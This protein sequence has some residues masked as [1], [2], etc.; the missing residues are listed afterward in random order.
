MKNGANNDTVQ[1]TKLQSFLKN[2]EKL[3]VDV[4]GIFDKKTEQAVI[5]FQNKYSATTMGPW[6]ASQGT[7]YVY[8]TTLKQINKIACNLPLTLNTQ[9]LATINAKKNVKNSPAIIVKPSTDNSS[10]QIE[11][12]SEDNTITFTATEETNEENT[13]SVAKPSIMNRFLKFL[14]YLFK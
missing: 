14:V 10:I 8:I 4:T 5:A 13:A 7:G 3:N 9:E 11:T 6:G 12:K 1:V 2:V